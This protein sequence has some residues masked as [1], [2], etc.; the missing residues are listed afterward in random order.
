MQPIISSSP[1]RLVDHLISPSALRQPEEEPLPRE[2][3][4][5]PEEAIRSFLVSLGYIEETTGKNTTT[6]ITTVKE[7]LEEGSTFYQRF[8]QAYQE[9]I[10]RLNGLLSGEWLFSWGS[11]LF[12]TSG[13][14]LLSAL[15]SDT[16]YP[17][18]RVELVG[19]AQ[20]YIE[21]PLFRFLAESLAIEAPLID[22]VLD[23]YKEEPHQV[24]LLVSLCPHEKIYD[25]LRINP[26]I[27][28]SSNHHPF[29]QVAETLAD[30]LISRQA[31]LPSR[32]GM[33]ESKDGSYLSLFF[34]NQE[35]GRTSWKI[36]IRFSSSAPLGRSELEQGSIAMSLLTADSFN[37][38]FVTK[39]F[40][41]WLQTGTDLLTRES[42]LLSS[43]SISSQQIWGCISMTLEQVGLRCTQELPYLVG[44]AQ[45]SLKELNI[46]FI[47]AEQVAN[48]HHREPAAPLFL[49]C[50]FIL[51]SSSY[52]LAKAKTLCPTL[53]TEDC[54]AVL[55]KDESHF[56]QWL[57]RC[58]LLK[59]TPPRSGS[60]PLFFLYGL[61][62]IAALLEPL[63]LP[64]D[65]P[66][67]VKRRSH[68]EQRVA[69]LL[70]QG[71]V[72]PICFF[73]SHDGAL[74]LADY[75]RQL[76]VGEQT[77]LFLFLLEALPWE[78]IALALPSS[79]A[80]V[81]RANP[82]TH[83][84]DCY[85]LWA[86]LSSH[87]EEG[88]CLALQLLPSLVFH[89]R[90]YSTVARLCY[91]QLGLVAVPSQPI[92]LKTELSLGLLQLYAASPG[93]LPHLL[94]RLLPH[95]PGST[96]EQPLASL[97]QDPNVVRMLL[98]CYLRKKEPKKEL[99][100]LLALLD[101][102][103]IC[104]DG[105]TLEWLLHQ[106]RDRLANSWK[107][108]APFY[109]QPFRLLDDRL[110]R[111]LSRGED[112]FSA[113]FLFTLLQW[114]PDRWSYCWTASQQLFLALPEEK[115]KSE[116]FSGWIKTM[117][118]SYRE[119]PPK[120]ISASSLC[121]LLLKRLL[122][123]PPTRPLELDLVASLID[124][125]NQLITYGS[126]TK[127]Q[128]AEF[129]Q[130]LVELLFDPSN[131]VS[132][133]AFEQIKRFNV[134]RE[135]RKSEKGDLPGP[136]VSSLLE[137]LTS[138]AALATSPA[139]LIQ[140]LKATI[141]PPLYE[142]VKKGFSRLPSSNTA[143]YAIS[144]LFELYD[145]AELE[146]KNQFSLALCLL[147]HADHL[148]G[149]DYT[150]VYHC[151]L[152]QC[153][154][155][156]EPF[157]HLVDKLFKKKGDAAAFALGLYCL[158]NLLEATHASL[159]KE[160]LELFLQQAAD[161]LFKE[162]SPFTVVQGRIY[163]EQL[164]YCL[165]RFQQ[166]FPQPAM[167]LYKKWQQMA[168]EASLYEPLYELAHSCHLSLKGNESMGEAKK[169]IRKKVKDGLVNFLS[170]DEK[171]KTNVLHELR[172]LLSLGRKKLAKEQLLYLAS[173]Y[174]IPDVEEK[175]WWMPTQGYYLNGP[176]LA[177]LSTA[178]DWKFLS[179]FLTA[180]ASSPCSNLLAKDSHFALLAMK[181][182]VEDSNE[183]SLVTAFLERL[184]RLLVSH[185]PCIE[186]K[187]ALDFETKIVDL[188]I[189]AEKKGIDLSPLLIDF[190][191]HTSEV[192]LRTP[193]KIL[194]SMLD[195]KKWDQFARR[196]P[197]TELAML[198]LSVLLLHLSEQEYRSLTEIPSNRSSQEKTEQQ[199]SPY[200]Q[201][202][203]RFLAHRFRTTQLTSRWAHHLFTW[204]SQPHIHPTFCTK[205]GYHLLF[206][207]FIGA[208]RPCAPQEL[209]A[210][211]TGWVEHPSVALNRYT[212]NKHHQFARKFIDALALAYP[213]LSGKDA[214]MELSDKVERLAEPSRRRK[215]PLNPFNVAKNDKATQEQIQL[216]LLSRPLYPF[217][218]M[219]AIGEISLLSD[220][221]AAIRAMSSLVDTV[222]EV[223][224]N[225]PTASDKAELLLHHFPAALIECY[226]QATETTA[227][228]AFCKLFCHWSQTIRK[229]E[230]PSTT[231]QQLFYRSLLQS[232]YHIVSLEQ[233]WIANSRPLQIAFFVAIPF[234]LKRIDELPT[235]TSS[236]SF[237][238]QEQMASVLA[239][240]YYS[241]LPDGSFE[242]LSSQLI[243]SIKK[244]S[245][246]EFI[247]K[248]HVLKI[249]GAL[250]QKRPEQLA[251][252]GKLIQRLLETF[253]GDK[254]LREPL[255]PPYLELF[256]NWFNPCSN[257]LSSR[258]QAVK[259]LADEQTSISAESF[260]VAL[261][262]STQK[263]LSSTTLE[264]S[265]WM[266]LTNQLSL[267]SQDKL[268]STMHRLI[269]GI[270]ADCPIRAKLINQYVIFLYQQPALLPPLLRLDGWLSHLLSLAAPGQLKN[271]QHLLVRAICDFYQQE[272]GGQYDK[273][274][275]QIVDQ[276]LCMLNQNSLLQD[277]RRDLTYQVYTFFRS[278]VD[279][280]RGYASYDSLL[281]IAITYAIESREPFAMQWA[282]E[283]LYETA[284]PTWLPQLLA[285]F[286]VEIEQL[287][288]ERTI[289]SFARV[290]ND[291]GR[292]MVEKASHPTTKHP[293]AQEGL[294]FLSSLAN[295][296]TTRHVE[297]GWPNDEI[298]RLLAA[299][300][301]TKL[302]LSLVQAP[303]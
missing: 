142:Q 92:Y 198:R 295:A 265:F 279:Y 108:E 110:S 249:V 31:Q 59:K 296:V 282:K 93:R 46:L 262:E 264:K 153:P 168:E 219:R 112:Y 126:W 123:S 104:F 184:F 129:D 127:A 285:L 63:S 37:S 213:H 14:A 183:P 105:D 34:A 215:P 114:L 301:A 61:E 274:G 293:T 66:L 166:A 189:L 165:Q 42:R 76:S 143:L 160:Q 73:L 288:Q 11:Y 157:Y 261:I 52:S 3:P 180:I 64:E 242:K 230:S 95:L 101:N 10:E 20:Y 167:K 234:L 164:F 115:I 197:V 252:N 200:Q 281:E 172:R 240:L 291:H 60:S 181:R 137:L 106:L 176:E 233:G 100:H 248:Q 171:K 289:D 214:F 186:T 30:R 196:A 272:S 53:E 195:L 85:L 235:F 174:C 294:A 228:A 144:G 218:L 124:L 177:C 96:N 38:S 231:L 122:R 49:F 131:Y 51:F 159:T 40:S 107:Q 254:R 81:H 188:F 62:L 298:D 300:E 77:E 83:G 48:A 269:A 253:E 220:R 90:S 210:K 302:A 194:F 28:L 91:R 268:E 109:S 209:L 211:L 203:D 259:L 243:D 55:K 169:K 145:L 202:L 190:L 276:F 75:V 245:K 94:S 71:T 207:F 260:L 247:S 201:R 74:E 182:F 239:Y 16:V 255:F 266:S 244:M 139:E 21:L 78:Q 271:S 136:L 270:Q 67:L 185:Q 69:T 80:S 232:L 154:F 134:E 280:Y 251:E 237:L 103:K 119:R 2:K 7:R 65:S 223:D 187:E 208:I 121:L 152:S 273:L 13:S 39:G 206:W 241:N 158:Q 82:F 24:D 98:P 267:G 236:E 179:S 284:I 250:V 229:Q 70:F 140:P 6:L 173:V 147:R 212:L 128:R 299:I 79:P 297:E 88:S 278:L 191:S 118:N 9:A 225:K 87:G 227:Q 263:T 18:S 161:S 22:S 8:E 150:K 149:K 26:I 205:V 132:R 222:R 257:D 5:L 1:P 86:F 246:R 102:P 84:T 43:V 111:L 193:E 238:I 54:P 130:L 29:K 97:C 204:F 116:E 216:L 135:K 275:K 27:P 68:C 44:K 286:F 72:E 287:P 155:P 15:P 99:G 12:R 25:P 175:D 192:A 41:Q 4:R 35:K 178:I 290:L 125:S 138:I 283:R 33:I 133:E 58:T 120:N 277:I 19:K 148:E 162:N 50:Q 303:R 199:L 224:W 226:R 258:L 23:S 146:K 170:D 57:S 163:R 151:L 117:T 36:T 17:G 256:I 47:N 113:E 32:T 89:P 292:K 56:S 221:Q 45:E 156:S 141:E 217:H